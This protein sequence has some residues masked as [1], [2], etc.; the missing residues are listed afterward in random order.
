MTGRIH[1]SALVHPGARL[2]ADVEVGPYC[3]IGADAEIGEGSWVGAHVVIDGRVRIG[4]RNRRGFRDHGHA[5]HRLFR[6]GRDQLLA[7]AERHDPVA[8][9]GD[10]SDVQG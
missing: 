8:D 2:A 4:R 5:T 10:L 6:S 3:V 7:P 1:P 9:S